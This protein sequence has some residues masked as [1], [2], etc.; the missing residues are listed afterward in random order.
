M[1]YFKVISSNKVIDVLEDPVWVKQGKNELVRRCNAN[2]AMGVVSSDSEKTWHIDGMIAFVGKNY[3]DVIV[4]DI[5]E[6]EADELKVLLNLG[7]DIED[8]DGKDDVS[9]EEPEQEEIPTVENETVKQVKERALEKLSNDCQAVIYIGT[10][11]TLSDGTTKHFDLKIEDQLNLITLS[12]LIASGETLIPYH[13]SDELCTYYSA[14]DIMSVIDTATKYKTYHTSYYNS[15]KNW[16]MSMDS[17]S[18]I[19]AVKY[20]D[21]IPQEFCSEVLKQFLNAEDNTVE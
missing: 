8:V 3:E 5:T 1:S 14:A 18:E 6:D 20:G 10:D 17:I 11:V 13:A 21:P 15:L 12:T 2:D 4:T 16:V 9:W 19:G 7:A